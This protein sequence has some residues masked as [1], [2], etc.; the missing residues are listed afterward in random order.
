M[1][2]ED[3]EEDFE[4]KERKLKDSRDYNELNVSKTNTLASWTSED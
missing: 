4:F 3:G 2:L 1:E